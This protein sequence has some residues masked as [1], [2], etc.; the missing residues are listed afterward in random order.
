MLIGVALYGI[1]SAAIPRVAARTGPHWGR[2]AVAKV[3]VA[4]LRQINGVMGPNF[5]TKHR[6]KEG[7]VVLGQV[8][9]LGFGAVIGGGATAALAAQ[10][11][12]TARRAFGP[13]PTS[14]PSPTPGTPITSENS[15]G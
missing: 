7:I 6:T 1:G 2:Q 15:L 4:R 3:P 12:W 5:V 9:P 10:H 8:A 14:W 13:P 11:V